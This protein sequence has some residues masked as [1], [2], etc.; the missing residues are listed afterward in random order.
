VNRSKSL[1]R[2]AVA[3]AGAAAIG[4]LGAVAIAAPA[5]AHHSEVVGVPVCNTATGDWVVKWTVNSIAPAGV[6]NFKLVEVSHTPADTTLTGI[7]VTEGEGYGLT[8]GTPVVGEQKVSG[9]VTSASLTVK[10]KWDNGF[11][12]Q[13][14]KT[15]TVSFKEKCQQDSPKPGVTDASNCD[16]SVIVKLSNSDEA[17]AAA[18]FE[19]VGKGGFSK[20]H[21]LKPGEQAEVTVPAKAAGE[22]KVLLN[23]KQFGKT[24]KWVQSEK[25]EVPKFASKSDCDTLTIEVANP[26]G[27]SPVTFTFTPAEGLTKTLEVAPGETKTVVYGGEKAK[28]VVVSSPGFESETVVWEKPAN[29]GG[30]GG[31]T[32][33]KTGMKIGGAIAGALV[34]LA[35]GGVL[36]I[37]ARRRRVTFTA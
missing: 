26:K 14:A 27:G 12:E 24:I 6:H 13:D 10:S 35:I 16:G 25:C 15:G 5:S 37:V 2:R 23:G 7:A 32:L 1:L 31:G 28:K 21:T 3:V 18:E 19:V 11:E 29:C 4:L 30:T 17:S 34:L 33:P 8:V 36:F 20:K 22:I 9:A